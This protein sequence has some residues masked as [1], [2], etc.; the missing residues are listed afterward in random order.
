MGGRFPRENV[1]FSRVISW[2]RFVKLLAVA[3]LFAGTIGAFLPHDLASRRRAAFALAMPGF[4]VVW[5]AGFLLAHHQEASLLSPWVLG[6]LVLSL[7]SLQL[8]IFGV[9]K[10]GR[11]RPAVASLAVLA[12]VACVAL[13]VW[14][15]S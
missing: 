5:I 6:A 11:R 8:V 4:G 12:L 3:A 14:K 15:P 13:M 9:A 2:L 1:Q 10:D 7:T